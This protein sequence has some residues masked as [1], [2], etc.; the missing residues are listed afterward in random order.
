MRATITNILLLLLFLSACVDNGIYIQ[1]AWTERNGGHPMPGL[2]YV[3]DYTN[4]ERNKVRV[5]V[6][7]RS[8]GGKYTIRK[9]D[10]LDE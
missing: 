1:S 9:I 10:E 7:I 6:L 8:A 4:P 2:F 3:P 5:S